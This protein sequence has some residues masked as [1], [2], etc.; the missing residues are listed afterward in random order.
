MVTNALLV[1][2][3]ADLLKVSVIESKRVVIKANPDPSLAEDIAKD[4][5]VI[6]P[7]NACNFCDSFL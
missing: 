7:I 4:D 1:T 3:W 5:A 6:L 2:F